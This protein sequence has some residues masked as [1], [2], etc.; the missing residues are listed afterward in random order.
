MKTEHRLLKWIFMAGAILV[1]LFGFGQARDVPLLFPL[2]WGAGQF[3]F[4]LDC[5]LGK[6]CFVAN[7][8]DDDPAPER[9]KDW[10]CGSIT[11]DGHNGT[12]YAIEGW[13]AMDQG[14][15]VLA[16]DAGVV[17]EAIDGY[18]DRCRRSCPYENSNHVIIR[19]KNGL[20][21]VY[22]HMKKGSVLVKR[23]QEVTKGQKIGEVGSSG[24][25]DAPH[26][27]FIVTD[28]EINLINPYAG[29]CSSNKSESYW[30]NQEPYQGGTFKVVK[31][32]LTDQIPDG[33]TPKPVSTLHPR[34]PIVT[35]WLRVLNVQAGDISEWLW[36]TPQGELYS[37]CKVVHDRPY[38][39]SY[40]YCYTTL[41]GYPGATKFGAWTVHYLH[42][43]TIVEKATFDL[44]P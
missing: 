2:A 6:T 9:V 36:Y 10:S 31:A 44:E 1:P 26:L 27:H 4:P 39:Y 5:Q 38:A 15:D 7:Y 41:A 32:L 23:G 3:I 30:E 8:M 40:W 28:S 29:P 42:N 18:Y 43:G 11:Y 34:D 19:H 25:S 21:T 14:V 35:L 20:R 17:I 12:D 13:E 22:H 37:R 33:S 24:D 16:A